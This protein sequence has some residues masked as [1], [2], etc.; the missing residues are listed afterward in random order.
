MG[1]IASIGG[2]IAGITITHK[3]A[4][5]E[6]TPLENTYEEAM[7]QI[8]SA[9]RT[10]RFAL[11]DLLNSASSHYGD[12]YARWAEVT[13]LE[14]ETLWNIASVCR[15]V[16][17]DTRQ[18][19]ALSF[20]HHAEVASLPS[21]DQEKWL[22]VAAEKGVPV[23]RLRKSIQLGRLA[24]AA[25]MGK[26]NNGAATVD[27]APKRMDAQDAGYENVHPHVNRLVA[28]LAK[29]ERD[30]DFEGMDAEELYRFHLD[31]LPAINRWGAVMNM[32][33]ERGGAS[34]IS[35]LSRDLRELGLA[36]VVEGE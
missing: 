6:G 34:T 27:P 19:D 28:Y 1:Q 7:R 3:G 23:Q 4:V 32:I 12:R 15:R 18:V 26:G 35:M 17:M 24:T 2:R 30:G 14:I 33:I 36:I 22:E 8:A 31:L 25:D 9:E 21:A 20:G 29:K 16:P 5:V 10:C 13:G 11:G